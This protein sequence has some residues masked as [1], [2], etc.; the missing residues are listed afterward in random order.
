M[1]ASELSAR[2]ARLEAAQSESLTL[3][4]T[5]PIQPTTPIL[6][7]DVL[8]TMM[9]TM[10][11]MFQEER[12]EMREMVLDILQ[13]RQSVRTGTTETVP[14]V[15]ETPTNYDPELTPIP[16]EIQA[17][18][19]RETNE[20]LELQHLLRERETLQQR[21][22]MLEE[23]MSKYDSSTDSFSLPLDNET[24]PSTDD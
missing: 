11:T 16:P 21:A 2:L 8:E 24:Y 1:R 17:V 19:D 12:R 22:M 7:L 20:T 9:T 13:G 6:S 5:F 18:I 10:R 14:I 3:T 15:N 4:P 23:E